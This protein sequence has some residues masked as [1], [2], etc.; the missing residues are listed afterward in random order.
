MRGKAAPEGR[1]RE[2]VN[3]FFKKNIKLEVG[4]WNVEGG[5]WKVGGGEGNYFFKKNRFFKMGRNHF[6]QT[7]FD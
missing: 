6:T 4:R 1:P 7:I 5:R 2:G 3:F